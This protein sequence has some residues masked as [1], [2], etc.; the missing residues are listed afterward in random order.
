MTEVPQTPPSPAAA[1]APFSWGAFIGGLAIAVIPGGIANI[2]FGAMS[3]GFH[4]GLYGFLLGGAAGAVLIVIGLLSR[5]AAPAFAAGL[6]CGGCAVGLIGG[7][8]GASMVNTSF[9]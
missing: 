6:I 1:P 9:R 7:I 4:N 8:C 5:R 3:M 2:F